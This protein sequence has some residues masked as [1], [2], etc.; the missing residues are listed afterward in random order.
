MQRDIAVYSADGE[1]LQWVDQR[2]FQ[3]LAEYGRIARVVKTR[4]GRVKRATLHPIAGEPRPSL[5]SDYNGTKYCFRQQLEDGHQCFRLRAL[6]DNRN[7]GEHYLGPEEVRPIFM[8]V[9]LDCLAPAVRTMC[10]ECGSN[11]VTIRPYDFGICRQTGYNDAGE[12]FHCRACGARGAA[13]DIVGVR[14]V[15]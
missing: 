12:H 15:R 14:D 3:R 5:L 2:R 9:L 6:G 11:D 4:A 8:R 13:S 10:P 7:D 1:L